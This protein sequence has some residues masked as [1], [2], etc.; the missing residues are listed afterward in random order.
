LDLAAGH[1]ADDGVAP[2]GQLD[3]KAGGLAREKIDRLVDRLRQSHS[4]AGSLNG[5]RVSNLTSNLDDVR[6]GKILLLEE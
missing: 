2:T 1:I 3:G 4:A 5:H 6:Q